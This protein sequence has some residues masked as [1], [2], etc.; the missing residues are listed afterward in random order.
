MEF[1]V[2]LGGGRGHGRHLKQG[3]GGKQKPDFP[4]PG[5]SCGHFYQQS[6]VFHARFA[7]VSMAMLG[8]GEWALVIFRSC[9]RDAGADGSTVPLALP[10]LRGG[11][12]RGKGGAP[13]TFAW[14]RPWD[15]VTPWRRPGGGGAALT[16][17]DRGFV[18]PVGHRRGDAVLLAQMLVPGKATQLR[19]VEWRGGTGP[20]MPG[21]AK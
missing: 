15:L 19:E 12:P 21:A 11:T 8:N 4:G 2:S 18:G 3:L 14:G 6:P 20:P 9:H 5:P 1:A 7:L 16:R 17:G 13:G 10:P